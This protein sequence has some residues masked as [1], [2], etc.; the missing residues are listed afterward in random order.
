MHAVLRAA[1][2]EPVVHFL[3]FGGLLFAAQA[4]V[5]PGASAE[6]RIVVDEGVRRE[7]R[8][9]WSHQHDAPPSDD[10]EAA[11]VAQWV[12]DEILYREGLARGL[13]RDDGRVRAR[14]ASEMAR[15]VEAEHP[16]VEPTEAE[17][18]AYFDAHASAYAEEPR[19]DFVHV[20]VDTQDPTAEARATE[21]LV[22]LQGGA[23]PAGLGDAFSGGRH[24]RGRRI[25]DLGRTFGPDF[26]DGLAEQPPGT[27]ALRRS[28]FGIHLV[29]VERLTQAA[30]ADFEA[31]R[32]DV[33]HEIEEAARRERMARA[34]EALRSEWDVVER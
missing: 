7:L 4:F 11:L 20:F 32:L 18:R 19:I 10:E 16:A 25:D 31:A 3:A 21:L 15:I 6:R 33:A 34:M 27:W 2:R 30:G 22:E 13:D 17:L 29:R 12:D 24:Y 1:L 5:H 26:V 8:D 28:R 23:A 9:A 14:V